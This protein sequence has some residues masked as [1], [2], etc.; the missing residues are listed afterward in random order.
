MSNDLQ[1]IFIHE[2]ITNYIKWQ[3]L[4]IIYWINLR[5]NKCNNKKQ[6]FLLDDKLYTLLFGYVIIVNKATHININTNRINCISASDTNTSNEPTL[7][8]INYYYL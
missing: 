2:T 5:T 6:M 4:S 3:Y 1:E 8:G 7:A